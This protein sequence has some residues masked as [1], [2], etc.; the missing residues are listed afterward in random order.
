M[1]DPLGLVAR[2]YLKDGAAPTE[3]TASVQPAEFGR[4]VERAGEGDD[5]RQRCRAVL[6]AFERVDHALR[7]AGNQT[8]DGPTASATRTRAPSTGR[9]EERAVERDQVCRRLVTVIAALE[10]VNDLFDTR[11]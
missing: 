8:K 3:T 2:A 6:P 5:A 9:A 1:H 7:F 10:T 4:A 11:R